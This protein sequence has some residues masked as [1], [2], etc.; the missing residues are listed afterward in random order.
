[1]GMRM[2][3]IRPDAAV[4]GFISHLLVIENAIPA[5]GFVLPLIANGHPSLIYQTMDSGPAMSEAGG[6]PALSLNGQYVNPVELAF[7]RR[8]VLV[9]CFFHAH[10]L[11][12][13]FGFDAAEWTDRHIDADLI[14]S[15]RDF[16]LR[17][18]APWKRTSRKPRSGND[19]SA[20]SPRRQN[21]WSSLGDRHRSLSFTMAR[22]R[23]TGR[24]GLFA[25]T[26]TPNP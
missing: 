14:G 11:K 24:L 18:C 8:F 25:P 10:A 13:L 9:A 17:P 4:S 22:S 15:A 2:D 23:L 16:R 7:P 26:L 19:C 21:S 6:F 20:V 12:P 1:M 5:Q 3:S